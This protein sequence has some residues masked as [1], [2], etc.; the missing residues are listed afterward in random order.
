[1]NTKDV[2]QDLVDFRNERNWNEFHSLINLAR[3]LNIEAA[4]VEKVFQWK[5]S[6]KELSPEDLEALKFEVAD[7]LTYSYYMCAKMNLDPNEIIEEKL[8][9]NQKRHWKFEE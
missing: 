7:V 3:A 5:S 9:E 6:D 4:E 8:A 1:M 2:M